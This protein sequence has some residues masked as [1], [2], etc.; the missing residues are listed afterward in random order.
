[1]DLEEGKEQLRQLVFHEYTH[2]LLHNRTSPNLIPV[3]LHEGLA[4]NAAGQTPG[5]GAMRG[6]LLASLQANLI[7]MPSK[8]TGEFAGIG[9]PTLAAQL[10][11]ESFLFVNHLLENEGGWSRVRS[12]VSHLSDGVTLADAFKKAYRKTLEELENRWLEGM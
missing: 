6:Q 3:W 9:D 10:Y 7:P 4:Q 2:A 8:L 1:M 11:L 5:N 12:L